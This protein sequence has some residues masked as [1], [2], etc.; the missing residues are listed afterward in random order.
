MLVPSLSQSGEEFGPLL[1]LCKLM[2]CS[3]SFLFQSIANSQGPDL[4]NDHAV[5]QE[6]EARH[7]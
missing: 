3:S 7:A 1:G 2:G 6:L 4:S 5:S